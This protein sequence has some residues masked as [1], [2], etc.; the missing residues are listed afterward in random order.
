MYDMSTASGRKEKMEQ[1]RS[2]SASPIE[3]TSVIQPEEAVRTLKNVLREKE[4]IILDLEYKLRNCENK[5]HELLAKLD[6]IGEINRG[7]ENEANN[8]KD[9][10]NERYGYDYLD[11]TDNFKIFFREKLIENN[12]Y[13]R[14]RMEDK[15]KSLEN[16]KR[17]MDVAQKNLENDLMRLKQ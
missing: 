8:L 14:K 11:F 2:R 17:A 16:E 13:Q 5:S 9:E 7:L 12:E 1:K 15:M 6:S 3:V 4:N 10:L